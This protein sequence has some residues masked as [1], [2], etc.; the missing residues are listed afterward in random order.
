MTPAIWGEATFIVS[1]AEHGQVPG[2]RDFRWKF[3][4]FHL[5]PT[6]QWLPD[7]SPDKSLSDGIDTSAAQAATPGQMASKPRLPP[8]NAARAN[9]GTVTENGLVASVVGQPGQAADAHRRC[10]SC[11]RP[12][13]GS[14]P[15][16]R[17]DAGAYTPIPPVNAA[18]ANGGPR[19]REGRPASGHHPPDR[20]QATPHAHVATPGAV[21]HRRGFRP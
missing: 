11:E 19:G 10:L 7:S 2:G 8:V 15:S 18:R 1:R 9:G 6:S 14:R 5:M 3:T 12:A 16:L 13:P 21:G 20:G 17:R 4:H